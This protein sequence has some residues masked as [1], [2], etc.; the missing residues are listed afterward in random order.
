MAEFTI[1]AAFVLIPLFLMIPLLG[2]FMDMKATTIQAAR[3]AA[4]E[5]T[6]WYGNS[7]WAAG[8]KS[9]A[10]IQSE[11]QQRFF[12]DSATAPLRSIDQAQ[13]GAVG[14]K[15]LWYDHS[16]AS[17]LLNY[18][19]EAGQGTQTPGT[20]DS[21]VS[22]AQKIVNVID[23]ITGAEFILDMKSQYTSKVT[24]NAANTPA[25]TLATGA[26]TSGFTAPSFV[27]RNVLVSNGWSANGPDFV[28]KQ[29]EGLA[30]LSLAGRSPIKEVM[31]VVQ[32]IAGVFVKE[33]EP[34]SLKLGGKVLPDF[35]PPDRLTASTSPAQPPGRTAEQR[36]QDE[37]DK[38]KAEADALTNSITTKVNA[39]QN[40]VG[41]TQNSIN[42][43]SADK[44]AEFLA[45]Y[46]KCD[47]DPFTRVK[48]NCIVKVSPGG[49]G[50]SYTPKADASVAC[51]GGLEAQIAALEAQLADP[52]L[53][54]AITKSDQQL[55]DNPDLSTDPV[56]IKNRNTAKAT[57]AAFQAQIDDLRRQIIVLNRPKNAL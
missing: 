15:L 56:F 20:M 22:K 27:M 35:V 50:T 37:A 45:N 34:S 10:Q 2:K 49:V 42:S 48:T 19:A 14:G 17:M 16:G 55:K 38:Q 5:R 53:Q 12:A 25:T 47:V 1:A 54:L 8:Q 44:Q 4:W 30:I 6:A 40:A 3:Y 24:L 31:N 43:C 36:R 28:K 9:D 7:E 33:L 46:Q 51:H 39:L 21:L 13:A 23:N 52:D 18:S 29:T 32:R 41:T 57:I 26:A 11:V